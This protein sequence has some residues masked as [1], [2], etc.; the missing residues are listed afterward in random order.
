LNR[1]KE[2]FINLKKTKTASDRSFGLFFSSIL[3]LLAI[4][5]FL[6]K[7]PLSF[8][9]IA[10]LSILILICAW[11]VPRIL[12]PFNL[13]WT[14]LGIILGTIFRPIIIGLIFFLLITP[15]A[16]FIKLIGRDELSINRPNKETYWKKKEASALD[17]EFFK[18]QF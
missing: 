15:T 9:T 12:Y 13:I 14:F 17:L 1:I 3:G 16:L 8:I 10:L 5:L 11:L 6:Y 18:N 4:Y 2:L 7:G